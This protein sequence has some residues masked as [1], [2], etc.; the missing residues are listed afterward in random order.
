MIVYNI[1]LGVQATRVKNL[2]VIVNQNGGKIV[3]DNQMISLWRAADG[4]SIFDLRKYAQDE[5]LPIETVQLALACLAE[6]GLL[7]REGV[8]G[9]KEDW[10]NLQGELVSVVIVSH[11]SLEWLKPCLESILNQTYSP[12][13]IIIVDNASQDGTVG[14]VKM[15]YPAVHVVSVDQNSPLSAAINLGVLEANGEFYLLLNPDVQLKPDAISQLVEVANQSQECAAVAAKLRFSWAPEFLN[16]LGN[17]VGAI[18]WGMDNGLGHLDLGQFDKWWE[19]PSACFAATLIPKKA[20]RSVGPIDAQFPLYYEDS[21]WSYRARLMGY[22]VRVAPQAVIY[23][24]FGSSVPSG[25]ES[26]LRPPKLRQVVYGRLRFI[27][28]ILGSR[29]LLRFLINYIIEDIIRIISY[30]LQ[31]RWRL[32]K[33]CTQGWI[34]YLGTIPELREERKNVQLRRTV[35]DSELFRMQRIIPMPLILGGLP[36]LTWDIVAH[37]YQPLIGSGNLRILPEFEHPAIE[38]SPSGN[39]GFLLRLKNISNN[40]GMKQ[41]LHRGLRYFQWH[42]RQ[43]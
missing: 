37:I 32:I 2:P 7:E 5:S 40:E 34:D 8:E 35:N 3:V 19:V 39:V 43:P 41:C 1:P 21:E 30:L 14:W 15:K 4:K 16:G 20:W 36:Q 29:F 10:L 38:R 13:E 31:G 6:A 26:E 23:H 18:S 24:A 17:S 42:L 9:L 12:I 11:N 27:S 33:A 22:K 28:K 25:A